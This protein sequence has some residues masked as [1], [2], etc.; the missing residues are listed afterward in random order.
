MIDDGNTREL[1]RVESNVKS[2]VALISPEDAK[3]A[4]TL[5]EGYEINLFAS[6]VDFL[7]LKP[8]VQMNSDVKRRL[9]VTTMPSYPMYLPGRPV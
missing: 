6:E 1:V 7:D 4:F 2:P 8:P 3:K 9:W 5:P